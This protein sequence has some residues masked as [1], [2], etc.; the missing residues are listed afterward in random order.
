MHTFEVEALDVLDKSEFVRLQLAKYNKRLDETP[1]N[2]QIKLLTTKRD[3]NSPLYLAWACDELRQ[4]SQFDTLNQKIK[5]LPIKINQLVDYILKRLETTFGVT[6]TNAA[7]MFICCARDG[8]REQELK[9]LM[10]LYVTIGKLNSLDTVNKCESLLDLKTDG[11][12]A[13][14][15]AASAHT[16]SSTLKVFSFIECIS[17]TF[18]KP[19]SNDVL[20]LSPHDLVKACLR[21]KYGSNNLSVKLTNKLMALYYWRQVDANLDKNWD[22]SAGQRAFTYL[23]YHL[24]LSNLSDLALVL[25]DLTFMAAKCE[26]NLTLTLM[27]DFDLHES[28]SANNIFLS[29]G[30]VTTAPKLIVSKRDTLDTKLR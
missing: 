26:L 25:S 16:D 6:F 11:L 29:A 13:K 12:F 9:Q 15:F 19:R 1:F 17:Q 30:S 21:S 7:F 28:Y 27:D 14:L 24:S 18:L 8:L 20:C 22:V 3:A 10:E 5:E 4:F 23:P 2:N